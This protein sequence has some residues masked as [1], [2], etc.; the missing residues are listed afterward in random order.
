MRMDQPTE[1]TH[2]SPT[3]EETA[4]SFTA[5]KAF[6]Y[7]E[8]FGASLSCASFT[9]LYL[10]ALQAPHVPPWT[11]MG[12]CLVLLAMGLF[13]F[14]RNRAY[15]ERLEFRWAA[16]WHTAAYVVAGAGAVFWLLFGL[17]LLLQFL[18]IDVGPK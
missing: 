11:A 4:A 5:A 15:Y 9:L 17:L 3:P 13:V 6:L 1:A 18:G 10:F 14:F 7:G 2:P 8:W 12:I 16:R